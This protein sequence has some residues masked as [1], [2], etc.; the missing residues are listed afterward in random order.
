LNFDRTAIR[1][2][3]QKSKIKNRKLTQENRINE[4]RRIVVMFN[5]IPIL[6]AGGT[7]ISILFLVVAFISWLWNVFNGNQNAPGAGRQPQPQAGGKKG[8]K[9]LQAEI[10]RFLKNVMGQKPGN[11]E[12]LEVLA[13]ED[14]P[15]RTRQKQ[16]SKAEAA[17]RS[18][19]APPSKAG[20][21]EGPGDARPGGRISQ[22]KGPGSTS[23]GSGVRQHVAEHMQEGRVTQ[24]A[25]GHLAHGV[26]E[27]VQQ[28]LGAFTG[29]A[30]A[31]DAATVTTS[32]Q[33]ATAL[34][35]AKLM[36]D[37]VNLKEAFV[38]NLILNRRSF[39]QRK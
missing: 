5:Q 13:V 3:N 14:E 7:A 30:P 17:K 27:K 35:V 22:R 21:R 34:S 1:G 25:Q 20:S 36:R 2:L 38:L 33:T 8:E 10:N 9:D 24:E 12:E 16:R 18:S 4:E 23:L 26:A 15:P 37:P 19:T 31:G 32:R 6:A 29:I 39:S 28:D 11:E